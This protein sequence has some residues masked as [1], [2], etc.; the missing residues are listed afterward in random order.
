MPAR[1]IGHTPANM[2]HPLLSFLGRRLLYTVGALACLAL[3]LLIAGGSGRA[4]LGAV[5]LDFAMVSAARNAGDD[6]VWVD[7]LSEADRAALPA[8][9]Q[10]LQRARVRAVVLDTD[11]GTERADSAVAAAAGALPVVVVLAPGTAPVD[12]VR[13]L[14]GAPVRA[15][16]V[17]GVAAL[18]PALLAAAHAVALEPVGLPDADGTYRA[19]PLVADVG[20]VLLPS[21]MLAAWS[22]AHPHPASGR[23]FS[24]PSTVTGDGATLDV[25]DG[26]VLPL[27]GPP[28]G[29]PGGIRRLLA[30]ELTLPEFD[31][32][33]L[34]GRLVVLGHGKTERAIVGE[35]PATELL[36]ERIEAF[37][38]GAFAASPRHARLWLVGLCTAAILLAALAAPWLTRRFGFALALLIAAGGAAV[39]VL[40][41]LLLLVEAGMHLPLVWPAAAFACAMIGSASSER[42][43][44]DHSELVASG[45]SVITHT[46]PRRRASD[47]PAPGAPRGDTITV[48]GPASAVATRTGSF[49][50]TGSMPARTDSFGRTGGTNTLRQ[51]SA[52]LHPSL[53]PRSR[54]PANLSEP[55]SLA[56]IDAAL[57]ALDKESS[58]DVAARLLAGGAAPDRRPKIGRFRIERELGRGALSTVYLAYDEQSEAPV[59]LKAIELATDGSG[60][61]AA[62]VRARFF[63]E[64]ETAGRLDHPGIVRVH[65]L[66]EQGTLAYLAMDFVEGELLSAHTQPAKLLPPRSVLLVLASVAEA[67]DHAHAAGIVHRDI[68]PANVMFD[69]VSLRARVTDF[70]IA[71]VSDVSQ[72]R[73]GIVLGTPSFMSPEQL[74]GGIVTGRSDL[75][76]LGV[77][78]FQLLTGQLP[79]MADSMPGLMEKIATA[80]HPPLAA[81]RPDLAACIGDVVD[82]ALEKD[83]EGRYATAGEM[84]QAMRECAQRITS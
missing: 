22:V 4:R 76:A 35:R 62:E 31:H 72:T 46:A 14:E 71:K 47:A 33:R 30:S 13:H 70:G 1:G 15:V 37:E 17:A 3:V 8:M 12:Q 65:D 32:T 24:G 80:P 49:S 66:G 50:R 52:P 78:L 44:Q 84:A 45:A 23:L 77:T 36:A 7:V 55:R 56:D 54:G 42:R 69:P 64:A 83:P 74:E 6:V 43:R 26:R 20:G 51:L 58:D 2:P 39:L 9:L 10:V 19:Y 79:F 18:A 40:G 68:K 75:F 34:E 81:I 63:R 67:L 16:P 82:R 61:A 5:P 48:T 29:S 11:S 60:D 25:G 41:E 27:L 59:A 57:R 53:R 21:A 73:A 38:A 28:A